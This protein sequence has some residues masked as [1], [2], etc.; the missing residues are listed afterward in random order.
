MSKPAVGR[1]SKHSPRWRASRDSIPGVDRTDYLTT[2]AE[3]GELKMSWYQDATAEPPGSA[4]LYLH[5]GA[6]ILPPLPIYDG[7]TRAYT[8]ATGV[9][10]LLVD[11][12][13][14]PEHPHPIPIQ[15]GFAALCWLAANADD[16]GVDPNRI[17]VMGDSAGG[18]LA[19]AVALMARDRGGP[20][21]A[22]QLL[23]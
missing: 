13:V 2:T 16:L 14:A 5:G 20:A 18:G 11:Y 10:M 21:L 6:M 3:G 12:R 4:V 9:P 17:G 1:A 22:Q 15:D 7:M 19:A 23:I 8:K